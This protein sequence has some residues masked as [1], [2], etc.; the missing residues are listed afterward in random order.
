MSQQDRRLPETAHGWLGF[1]IG[2]AAVLLAVASFGCVKAFLRKG[3]EMIQAAFKALKSVLGDS[4]RSQV[5]DQQQRLLTPVGTDWSAYEPAI[6][7]CVQFPKIGYMLI[8]AYQAQGVVKRS[9]KLNDRALGYALGA[10]VIPLQPLAWPNGD[11]LERIVERCIDDAETFLGRKCLGTRPEHQGLIEP[12]QDSGVRGEGGKSPYRHTSKEGK[13]E[14]LARHEGVIKAMGVF[15]RSAGNKT[16]E[17]FAVDVVNPGGSA[18]HRVW[19]AD[20]ERAM[21]AVDA[22]PGDRVRID[23][24]GLAKVHTG[25]IREPERFMRRYE[26]TVL[27]R[28]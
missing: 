19:G 9:I 5:I 3:S 15:Q 18:E 13:P 17:Q 2:A 20:L 7:R 26:A 6:T 12:V 4:Q 28:A 23:Y 10:R 24:K 25:D 14:T 8:W 1:A 27:E 22:K 11:S 21:K 16:F